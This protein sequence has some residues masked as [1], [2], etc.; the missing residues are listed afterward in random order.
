[1]ADSDQPHDVIWK[2]RKSSSFP[3]ARHVKA[4]NDKREN[5]VLILRDANYLVSL[6]SFFL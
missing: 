3:G 4:G 6:I 5:K 2:G 1:M